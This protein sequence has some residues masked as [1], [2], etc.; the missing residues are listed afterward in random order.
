M[1]NKQRH[2]EIS[3]RSFGRRRQVDEVEEHI[4][5]EYD[6][7][8]SE[9]T[10]CD[11]SCDFHMNF[12]FIGMFRVKTPNHTAFKTILPRAWPLWLNSW[13][14]RASARGRTVSTT[15]FTL[16]ES[17]N[18]AISARSDELGCAP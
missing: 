8:Q 17:I 1:T 10:A 3:R 7:D 15:V 6:E 12:P 14:R 4:R 2:H 5:A 13:A 11:D 16:S 9:Q 18:I